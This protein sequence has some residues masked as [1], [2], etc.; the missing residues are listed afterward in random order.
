MACFSMRVK[1]CGPPASAIDLNERYV[2]PAA[3]CRYEQPILSSQ[4]A[5]Q[6]W[7]GFSGYLWNVLN[8][9][10]SAIL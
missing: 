1:A 4:P 2:C 5:F 3:V 10:V 8:A 9:E 6:F 7:S